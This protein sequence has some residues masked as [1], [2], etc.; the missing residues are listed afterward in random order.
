MGG[1]LW[2]DWLTDGKNSQRTN[3]QQDEKTFTTANAKDI[4]LWW[5]VQL[6]NQVREM[7]SLLVP[8]IAERVNTGSGPKQK[9]RAAKSSIHRDPAAIFPVKDQGKTHM[10]ALYGG[11]VLLVGMISD[12]GNCAGYLGSIP[13]DMI[14]GV[15]MGTV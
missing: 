4:K 9:V 14:L 5:K 1:R 15:S 2:G 10:A 13:G 3:W 11:T 8:L 6:E 7:H 12:Q